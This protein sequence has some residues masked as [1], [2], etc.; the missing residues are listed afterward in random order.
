MMLCAHSYDLW[1]MTY[2]MVKQVPCY[3]SHYVNVCTCVPMY[4]CTYECVYVC[5]CICVRCVW[6]VCL[7]VCI[8]IWRMVY[9]EAS[10]LL[11]IHVCTHAYM[12]TR[13][14]VCMHACTYV[15]MF[16]CIY[17]C[18]FVC[19]YVCMFVCIYKLRQGESSWCATIDQ[20]GVI[21]LLPLLPSHPGL[22]E[23][24]FGLPPLRPLL[25]STSPLY[26]IYIRRS[27]PAL[28]DTWCFRRRLDYQYRPTL[29][30]N[31]LSPLFR[32]PYVTF[33]STCS[34]L[35]F[36]RTLHRAR[37]LFYLL[38]TSIVC[39]N[40]VSLSLC[41]PHSLLTM[42][43]AMHRMYLSLPANDTCDLWL[44]ADTYMCV[45]LSL[46]LSLFSLSSLS[47]SPSLSLSLSRS[48]QS[49][50]HTL[51]ATIYGIWYIF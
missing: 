38:L 35:C 47:P 6:Y 34:S 40:F 49:V 30:T 14:H 7:C 20:E 10:A 4:V 3:C 27:A 17:V 31:H 15:C 29:A 8:H 21:Y 12:Y 16:V 23:F 22:G 5:V 36:L 33:R 13:V 11:H 32:L 25:F 37:S 26:I 24:F 43:V 44:T 45:S 2:H 18:T 50:L 51:L 41:H 19:L 48:V 42:I 1:Y 46:S 28:S 9:G 39:T